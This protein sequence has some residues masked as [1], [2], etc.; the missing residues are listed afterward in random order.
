MFEKKNENGK[1][2]IDISDEDLDSQEIIEIIPESP[3]EDNLEQ[4]CQRSKDLFDRL[5]RLQ[6]DFENYKKRMDARFSDVTKFASEGILLKVL[7]V[8]DNLVR[9]LEIDFSKNPDGAKE[10]V[11]A[12][13]QQIDKFLTLEGVRP[14]ES[15]GKQFDPYYQHAVST[16]NNPK[17]PDGIIAEEYQVGYM[18]KEKVLRPAIVCVNRHEDTNNNEVDNEDKTAEQDSEL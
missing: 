11:K 9:A 15:V 13:R 14:I 8:Y 17:L 7:E 1:T 2:E 6:A 3:I 18:I 10:G 5:Q 16:Q 12:I 4:E